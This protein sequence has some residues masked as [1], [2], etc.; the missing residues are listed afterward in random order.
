LQHPI[1][2]LEIFIGLL[3][4]NG[5]APLLVLALELWQ[6]W[7]MGVGHH[8][9]VPG[10]LVYAPGELVRAFLQEFSAVQLALPAVGV[11]R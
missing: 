8:C 3:L 2:L 6:Q 5:I 1:F 11:R 10:L 9:H 7:L 4:E